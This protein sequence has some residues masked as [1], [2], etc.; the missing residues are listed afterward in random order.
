LEHPVPNHHPS[1]V[2][3][4][5]ISAAFIAKFVALKDLRDSDEKW[6]KELLGIRTW[7]TITGYIPD[8]FIPIIFA[9]AWPFVFTDRPS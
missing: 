8:F 9:V 2:I 1:I 7:I 6:R 4:I 3:L 5:G